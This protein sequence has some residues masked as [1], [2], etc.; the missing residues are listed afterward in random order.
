MKRL[1]FAIFAAT[2]IGTAAFEA[3]ITSSTAQT[4]ARDRV[5]N[6]SATPTPTPAAKPSPTPEEDEVI[7]VE[8]ELVNLNVRVIDRTNRPINNLK[9]SEFTIF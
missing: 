9:Q 5:L 3:E 8:T 2:L 6:G 7:K 1:F 4:I